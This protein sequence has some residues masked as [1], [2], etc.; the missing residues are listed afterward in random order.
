METRTL[1]NILSLSIPDGFKRPGKAECKS[2]FNTQGK[3]LLYLNIYVRQAGQE[4][5]FRLWEQMLSAAR[6]V[7]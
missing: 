7:R 5:G 2:L 4:D 1:G 3:T 6:F